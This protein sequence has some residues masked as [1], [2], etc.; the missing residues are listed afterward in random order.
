MHTFTRS[1]VRSQTTQAADGKGQLVARQY[2]TL[3][4]FY[5]LSKICTVWREHTAQARLF[6][7]PK[8]STTS[9][10]GCDRWWAIISR[11]V[12]VS[13]QIFKSGW[14][15]WTVSL[16]RAE[17]AFFGDERCQEFWY[18]IYCIS[19][20]K[21]NSKSLWRGWMKLVREYRY[22]QGKMHQHGLKCYSEKKK[23]KILTTF[24]KLISCLKLNFDPCYFG[25]R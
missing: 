6:H 14:I 5:F 9:D 10:R 13:D 11:Q 8:I 3:M 16:I 21:Q 17:G 23:T 15:I 18:N 19:F 7:S 25:R 4:F 22:P 12:L 2:E 1:H 24:D 20:Q